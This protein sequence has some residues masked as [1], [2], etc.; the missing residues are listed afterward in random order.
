MTAKRSTLPRFR[1]RPADAA[2]R[3]RWLDLR[4]R[5]WPDQS[6][7]EHERDVDEHFGGRARRR[8][9]W[10]TLPFTVFLAETPPRRVIGFVEVDLRPYADGCDTSPVG[11]LEGWYVVPAQRRRG[12]GRALVRAAEAWA[13][14]LGCREMASDALLDNERSHRAHRAIGYEEVERQVLFRR[15]LGRSGRAA[16]TRSSSGPRAV[17]KGCGILTRPKNGP[18]GFLSQPSEFSHTGKERG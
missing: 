1:V 4:S 8:A 3:D 13:R 6:R 9:Q 11:Y 15:T 16:R 17:A 14:A 18:G 7:K 10:P 2:D 5:L 12:V